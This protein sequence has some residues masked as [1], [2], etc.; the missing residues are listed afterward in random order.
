MGKQG[1]KGE[2]RVSGPAAGRR[3]AISLAGIVA[4]GLLLTGLLAGAQAPVTG[5]PVQFNHQ[6][7][8][9]QM[10]CVFCHRFYEVREVAGRPELSRCMLCH[11]YR[12]ADDPEAKKLGRLADKRQPLPWIRHTRV[13]PSVRFSH[14]RHVVVG[15]VECGTCHGN[16]AQL[17]APPTEPLVP[18]T[19]Q[20]CLDCHLAEAVRIDQ[21]AL[22]ALNGGNLRPEVLE[23]LTTMKGARYRSN[24]EFLAVLNRMAG[25]LPPEAKK[26]LILAQLQ[27]AG[28]VTTDCIACHR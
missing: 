15:K 22:D 27:P 16:I 9:K 7:H 5:Q 12:A 20:F 24:G 25:G 3:A 21:Q 1:M 18:I 28:A 17:T 6:R 2:R 14:Q 8:V 11:A 10:T 23:A 13:I 4:V 19:M 26:N